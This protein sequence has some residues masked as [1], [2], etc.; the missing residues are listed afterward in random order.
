MH[1][2]VVLGMRALA[3]LLV[4]T[5]RCACA[6]SDV[7]AAYLALADNDLNRA[8][9]VS[10]AALAQPNLA[11]KTRGEWLAARLD[12]LRSRGELNKPPGDA[13][14]TEIIAQAKRHPAHTLLI[15]ELRLYRQLAKGESAEAFAAA[16]EL[17]GG[18]P[19]RDRSEQAAALHGMLAEVAF[20][21][22]QNAE[23]EPNVSA[24]LSIWKEQKG[25]HIR[26]HEYLLMLCRGQAAARLGN[27]TGAVDAFTAAAQL[28]ERDF[29]ADSSVRLDADYKHASELEQLGRF[30]EEL[31]LSESVIE[32]ARRHYGDGS[33]ETAEAEAGLGAVLQQLGDYSNARKHYEIAE[34]ILTVLPDAPIPARSRILVNFANVLQEIGDEDGAL[35]RY[36]A[37]LALVAQRKGTEHI[38]AIILANIGNTEFRTGHYADA[39]GHFLQAFELREVADGKQSPGLAYSLEGLGSIAL[40]EHEFVQAETYFRHALELRETE[41]S[42]GHSQHLQLITLRFGIAMARW[43]QGDLQGAF[44]VAEDSAERV[45]SLVTGIAANLPERQSVALREQLAPAT[46]LAVTLA[47]QRNDAASIAAAWR[48]VMLDRGMI[49]REE[50][51][52]IAEARAKSD[53]ALADV[54]QTWRQASGT[55]AEA[56]MRGAATDAEISTMRS[57]TELAERQFWDRLGS[58]PGD[59]QARAPTATELAAA[60]PADGVLVALAEGVA[61]DPAWP[62][63]A[64]RTQLPEDWYAFVL[65]ADGNTRLVR[66]GRIETIS[67]QTRAWYAELRD[68]NSDIAE[69]R[70]RGSQLRQAL[71]DPLAVMDKP[72][73]VFF[74]PD[75]EMFRVNLEALPIDDNYAV[76]R[77]IRVHTLAHESELLLPAAT[78]APR[79]LLAGAPDFSALNVADSSRQLCVSATH[80]GFRPLPNATRELESLQQVLQHASTTTVQVLAGAAAT[81]QEVIDALPGA[82]IIHL[83]THGF[84]LDQTCAVNGDTRAVTIAPRADSAPVDP[85]ALSGLAFAGAKVGSDRGLIGVLSAGEFA[86][87]DLSSAA[88]VVLS[89]C[90]SGLGPVGRSEGVFGMRRALRLAGA[91]TVVMSLWEVDD[92]STADLM[93]ALY[94]ARF[95]QHAEVPDAMASAMRSVLT[96]RRRAGQSEHPYYWAAFISEGGWR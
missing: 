30:R 26:W 47:A 74:V 55:L 53:P 94:Q 87:I 86:S 37:A 76:E 23:V 41:S 62:L 73:R 39:R 56:W 54:W 49:A 46:A 66:L 16:R 38:R 70:R 4:A 78:A 9:A 81:K 40:V 67:A 11:L 64:G 14:E 18:L 57:A 82:G 96:E 28:A 89:S 80:E 79:A 84:S 44:S 65:G 6:D 69:L 85:S 3:L 68:P 51:R 45:H 90:D 5:A 15:A 59:D 91:K 52:R 24:A 72:H 32:R 43:G 22:N 35:T 93:Q 13:L 8:D 12:V 7:D 1:A 17:V 77:G 71:L 36:N 33:M 19:A 63:I 61:A 31:L 34:Q 21:A 58:N 75:G 10:A 83:A 50:A 20:A 60:L 48:L 95:E 27:D 92:A 29:G 25:L 42:K 88:W 2:R